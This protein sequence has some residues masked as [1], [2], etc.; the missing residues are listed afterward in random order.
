MAR[1]D[2]VTRLSKACGAACAS[3]PHVT[4]SLRRDGWATAR[5]RRSTSSATR[6]TEPAARGLFRQPRRLDWCAKNRSTRR[7]SAASTGA[8]RSARSA[9]CGSTAAGSRRAVPGANRDLRPALH[10]ADGDVRIAPRGELPASP[11][12]TCCRPARCSSA[13]ARSSST[14]RRH[15]GLQRRLRP[16]RLRHHRGPPSARRDRDRRRHAVVLVCDGRRSRVDAGL[17]LG[18]LAAAMRDLGC[19]SAMNLDGGG[20]TTLVHRRHLLNRPYSEQDQAAPASRP[21]V[22]ALLWNPDPPRERRVEPALGVEARAHGIPVVVARVQRADRLVREPVDLP[23]MRA[24]AERVQR[25]LVRREQLEAAF[26]PGHQDQLD[27]HR[28]AAVHHREVGARAGHEAQR[29]Q[30]RVVG[31]AEPAMEVGGGNQRVDGL[32]MALERHGDLRRV[33][34]QQVRRHRC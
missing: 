26:G 16:V 19:H 25:L 33:G 7:S 30:P 29:D 11:P 5:R 18:E 15:R 8:T 28:V 3:M 12:A 13:T 6:S 32:P 2:P 23:P 20:S 14:G 17:T 9:T 34:R 1:D 10:V 22:T 24:P 27:G 31:A 21:I 4:Y